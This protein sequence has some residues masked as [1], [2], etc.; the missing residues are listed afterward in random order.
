MFEWPLTSGAATVEHN[1]RAVEAEQN[2][3]AVG[4]RGF[5]LA[6]GIVI[7]TIIGIALYISLMRHKP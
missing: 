7:I 6:S 2:P 1:V 4:S 5:M 3:A